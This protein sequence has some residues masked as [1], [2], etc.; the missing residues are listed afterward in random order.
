[1]LGGGVFVA[2]DVSYVDFVFVAEPGA[3][4]DAG[5]QLLFAGALKFEVAE[6]FEAIVDWMVF[7]VV[8]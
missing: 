5:S 1:M 7:E 4:G 8:V 6:E 2:A 3:K